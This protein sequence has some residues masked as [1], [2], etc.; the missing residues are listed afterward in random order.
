MTQLTYDL[1]MKA[2]HAGL[3]ADLRNS[4]I[5]TESAE[6]AILYGLAIVAG[7]DPLV[8]VKIPTATGQVFRGIAAE[9]QSKEQ[10]TAGDGKYN[11]EEAVNVLRKGVIWVTVNGNVVVDEPA[12]FV[13]TGT[14]AGKFRADNTDADLVP[15]GV[16]KS[17]AN[18]GEI[19]AIEINLP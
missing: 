5:E 1:Y 15:T 10:D 4:T 2:A 3:I 16:F 7:T 19:A 11:P 18:T 17:T 6:V 12:Y 8:Q 9:T 14:D 13:Y